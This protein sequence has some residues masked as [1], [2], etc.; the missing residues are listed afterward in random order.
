MKQPETKV[1]PGKRGAT[2][3]VFVVDDDPSVRLSL[4][5]LLESGDYS[6]ETFGSADEF[7]RRAMPAGPSCLVLDVRLPG[8]DGL[9]LQRKL[10]E[11]GRGQ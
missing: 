10:M 6:V 3:L 1:T 4:A 9:G 2:A 11:R 8:L 7:L 5:N